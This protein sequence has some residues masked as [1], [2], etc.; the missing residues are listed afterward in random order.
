[1]AKPKQQEGL[2]FFAELSGETSI[3]F[4]SSKLAWIKSGMDYKVNFLTD[5]RRWAGEMKGMAN[6]AGLHLGGVTE[7]F[8]VALKSAGRM[9]LAVEGLTLGPFS[10][11]GSSQT[12]AALYACVAAAKNGELESNRTVDLPWNT[13]LAWSADD[14]GKTYQGRGWKGVLQGQSNVDG[15]TSV[16]LKVETDKGKS[17][18]AKLEGNG[19]TSSGEIGIFPLEGQRNGMVFSSFTGGAHCCA[20]ISVVFDNDTSLISLPLGG[21]DGD[22]GGTF[23]DIDQD[24]TFE[25]ITLDQRFHYSFGPYV[26]SRPPVQI[27]AVDGGSV[28]DLTREPRY[29]DYLKA[30]FVIQRAGYDTNPPDV[31]FEP[32]AIAGLLASA[33]NLNLFQQLRNEFASKLLFGK[34]A[35]GFDTCRSPD[36]PTERKFHSLYEMIAF[37]FGQ[38]GYPISLAIDD[39]TKALFSELSAK[40]GFGAKGDESEQSCKMGPYRFKSNADGL[41]SISG[42]EMGCNVQDAVTQG[43]V[44]TFS[45]FCSG[46][47]EYFFTNFLISKRDQQL[48][49]SQWARDISE[50][51][52]G[53]HEVYFECPTKE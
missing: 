39:E 52:G 50:V 1:V 15:T 51:R 23:A 16:Y 4:T 35:D 28:K 32:A 27:L 38:W 6:P 53:N 13:M 47:G 30:Q 48:R 3:I 12:L 2:Y 9:S 5:A 11:G 18:T 34:P 22:T 49:V 8:M 40:P 44:S 33:S 17:L 45:A 26:A 31:E 41:S 7:Q 10:L 21:F 43:Q 36:C 25:F 29:R 24:G 37:R 20:L 19:A 14:Y 46:E 42:Y